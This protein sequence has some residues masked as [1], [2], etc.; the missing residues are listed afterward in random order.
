M[1]WRTWL[2]V[3]VSGLFIT[4]ALAEPETNVVPGRLPDDVTPVIGAWFWREETFQPEG[5]RKRLDFFRDHTVYNLLTTS[6]RLP[7]REVTTPGVHD[8]LREAIAYAKRCGMDVAFELDVRLAREA[9]QKA[10]PDELQEVLRLR[11]IELT[12]EGQATLRIKSEVPRDHMNSRTVPYLLVSSRLVRVYT[13][14]RGPGGIKAGTVQDVNLARCSMRKVADQNAVDVTIHCR[15]DMKGRTACIA[16]AFTH[17]TP[18]VFAPHLLDFQRS[19]IEQYG[20]LDLVG[21]LKDEWGFPPCYDGCPQKND[22]WYSE[23]RAAAYAERA[24]GRDL[25]RDCLLMYLGEQGRQAERQAAIN[26]FLDMSRLRNSLIEDHCYRLAKEFFGPDAYLFTHPT[27]MPYPGT[28]EFKKNGLHW[29]TATRNLAQTDECTPYCARTSLAKK[30]GSPVWFNQYYAKT[31][32]SYELNVWSHALGG[33]RINYHPLYPYEGDWY[34]DLL[35]R[36]RVMRAESR[37]RLLNLISSSPVDCPVA[38]IFGHACGMN[39]AG[40]AYDDVGLALTDKLWRE[41]FYADLIPSTEISDPALRINDDGF[42]QYGPQS[43][44][45]VVLYHPEFEQPGT[46][47]F[48]RVAAKGRTVLF[49]V[50]QWT[51][52]FNAKPF[53]GKTALPAAMTEVADAPT[54]GDLV[55]AKLRELGVEPHSPATWETQWSRELATA[56]PDQRGHLRLID[57][58]R[59]MLSGKNNVEGDLIRAEFHIGRHKVFMDAVGVAAVR[60][61]PNGEL[62][63]FAAGGLKRLSAPGLTIELHERLDIAYW[64]ENG[65]PRGVI[66]GFETKVPTRLK[67]FCQDWQHLPLPSPAP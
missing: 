44:S 16:V 50:G 21:I 45:V 32:E 30:W 53:D 23:A 14:E 34:G 19:I 48:F 5:Y 57:G 64:H 65:R 22:F 20:D 58:T 52:D 67:I 7:G 11:T 9:F 51:R 46:A 4:P 38:V 29:W 37:V 42:V 40:P 25:V 62:E 8:Q 60:L 35:V 24:G 18:D 6:C 33:G 43:Y 47:A 12:G 49:R 15:P 41:G 2:V 59:I 36:S 55:I 26:H 39:W 3:L 56:A 1:A 13:F 31:A 66:Q 61:D 17:L 63:A 10:Y 28:A 27:W 54:C